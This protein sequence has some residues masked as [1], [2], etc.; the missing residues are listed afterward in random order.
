MMFTF[1]VE[2]ESTELGVHLIRLENVTINDEINEIEQKFALVVEIGDDVPSN[3]TC[4]QR[5]VSDSGCQ[6][7]TGAREVRIIDDDRK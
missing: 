1:K 2:G 7:R 3:F 4:F 5:Q 6:S